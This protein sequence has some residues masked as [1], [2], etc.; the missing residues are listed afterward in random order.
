M[1]A[2]G[3][4]GLL[5][6]LLFLSLPVHASQ[7]SLSESDLETWDTAT[8]AQRLLP[9][10]VA[11]QA[12][13]HELQDK[14]LILASDTATYG[15]IRFFL[16]PSPA[17][18]G[19][20]R[21]DTHYVSL[22]Q[23]AHGDT[24]YQP[25]SPGSL[26]QPQLAISDD[27]GEVPDSAF[28]WLRSAHDEQDAVAMLQELVVI[29]D[30]ARRHGRLVLQVECKPLLPHDNPCQAGTLQVVRNLRLDR[31]FAIE[32]DRESNT[33]RLSIMPAGPGAP[34]FDTR[35]VPDGDTWR[36]QLTWQAPAPF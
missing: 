18:K 36:M 35:L 27:C 8:L 2:D 17:A 24:L 11:T 3:V 10:N 26:A 28:G 6:A 25:E 12:L 19:I 16:R 9:A 29:Q 7:T 33:W 20:C 21:R 13:S 15:A 5:A 1:K 4:S 32:S 22:K 14:P 23:L 30:Q 31:I 34:Y